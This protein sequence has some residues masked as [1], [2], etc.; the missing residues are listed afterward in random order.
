MANQ[1]SSAIA[2]GTIEFTRQILP[3]SQR[4][5][6]PNGRG[7]RYGTNVVVINPEDM[8]SVDAFAASGITVGTTPLEIV[9]PL[10]NPLPRMREVVIENTG[11]QD[12]FI[13]HHPNVELLDSFV[14]PA[15][16]TAGTSTRVTLPVLHNV[17]V[18]A[19]TSTGT[20]QVRLLIY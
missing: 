20:T 8:L 11:G 14:L 10:N 5:T 16:G 1:S 17:S 9:G 15:E 12:L 7:E 13:S 19:R 6:E 3:A 4:G 18:Y 2:S